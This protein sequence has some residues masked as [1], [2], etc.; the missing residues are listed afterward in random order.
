MGGTAQK[1][2]S[3]TLA[4][5]TAFI[6][7]AIWGVTFVQTKIL[8]NKGLRP[9]E[10]FLYRFALAYALMIPIAGKRIFLDNIKD[11]L[12]AV[13]P[14]ITGGSLYF[15]TENYAL[16]YGYC[17]N[18]SLLV[19]MTPL[20]TA[21]AVGALYPSERL[22]KRGIAGSIISL[23]GMALV[24]FNGNFVLKLSPVG[25][26]LALAACICWTVYSLV[27]KR[28]QT[29]YPTALLTRKIFGY[30][31][32]TI[33]PLFLY[34]K[35]HLDILFSGDP[36]VWSNIIA[37]GCVASMLCYWIWNYCLK[38]LGTVRATNFIYLNPVVTMIASAIVLDERITWFAVAGAAMIISGM[39]Y[40]DTGRR[41]K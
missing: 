15:V 28:L 25:D 3:L 37:L 22:S 6:I 1:S 31:L 8:I 7:V 24:V 9:D 30:G 36:V 12:F 40:M 21:L 34:N 4:Y 27:L 20:V 5:V 32:L 10:I 23:A 11:E 29:K 14:G 16:V 26:V 41:K 39:I 2:G 35:P 18:V 13:L 19:C 17:Y 33:M 38:I